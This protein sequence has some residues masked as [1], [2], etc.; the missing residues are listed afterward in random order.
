MQPRARNNCFLL[1]F[2]PASLDPACLA[3]RPAKRYLNKL[4]D[5]GIEGIPTSLSLQRPARL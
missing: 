2:D 4:L 1:S 5:I 3:E